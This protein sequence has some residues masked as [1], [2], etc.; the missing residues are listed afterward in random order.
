MQT[1]AYLEKNTIEINLKL[2]THGKYIWS[3]TSAFDSDKLEEKIAQLKKIDNK[4][5]DT[6]PTHA[7]AGSGRVANLEEY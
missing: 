5:K 3:I 4:L 2:T 6:F 7:K 1:F